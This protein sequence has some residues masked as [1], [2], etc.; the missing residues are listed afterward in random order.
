MPFD[1]REA[2]DLRS[3]V[4]RRQQ[5]RVRSHS[6][7]G[8]TAQPLLVRFHSIQQQHQ[9]RQQQQRQSTSTPSSPHLSLRERRRV[10]APLSIDTLSLKSDSASECGSDV[11]S[12]DLRE[13][14]WTP[15]HR[16]KLF[17]LA[18]SEGDQAAAKFEANHVIAN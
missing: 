4:L 5:V 14:H 12:E 10:P 2:T 1:T 13:E 18:M 17:C 15:E 3:Q 8:S 9:Q 16:D 11:S 7:S 6:F